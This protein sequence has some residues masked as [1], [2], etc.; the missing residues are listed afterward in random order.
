MI[1]LRRGN[2]W[3]A[4][5]PGSPGQVGTNQE[6]CLA[7]KCSIECFKYHLMCHKFGLAVEI[8]LYHMQIKDEMRLSLWA[9]ALPQHTGSSV[10]LNWFEFS[11]ILLQFVTWNSLSLRQLMV[12]ELWSQRQPWEGFFKRLLALFPHLPET[13]S[14]AT[15]SELGCAGRGRRN[16]LLK[17]GW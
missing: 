11:Y 3:S 14:A 5:V 12:R 7:I 8:N 1:P 2:G 6:K 17:T 15:R 10:V 4:F 9:T 16:H 13:D